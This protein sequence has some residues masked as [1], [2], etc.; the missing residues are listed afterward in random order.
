MPK[1]LEMTEVTS[2]SLSG[3]AE[4]LL[5]TLYIRAMESQRPDALVKDDKAVALIRQM[6]PDS[7]WVKRMM[8]DEEDK[9][10]LVLRNRQFDCLVRDILARR[11]EAVVVH[12]GC[13]LD[14]RFERVDNGKVEW[15][16]LDLP[17]V[18]ALRRKLIGDEGGRY[19]FLASSAFD[20]AWLGK[21]AIYGQRP[22]LFLAE[23]VLM[24]FEEAQ[25]RSLVLMLRDQFPSSELAFDAFSPFLVRMNNLRISRT[26]IGARYQWGLKRGRDL[27][28]WGDGIALLSEW[29]PFS[30]P[31]PRLAHVSW[32]R[33]IPLLAR[34]M[35]VFHYRLGKAGG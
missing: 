9:V 21:V 35:G 19:H 6:N 23:G 28:S 20:G 12:I 14:S 3:V 30:C 18:I 4:T 27:E 24:Y 13:G 10:A 16:D 29:F 11:P 17:E 2:P 22:F 8:V 32:M 25:V 31:E 7:S 34:V 15:Y 5:L 1:E 26:K 33:H